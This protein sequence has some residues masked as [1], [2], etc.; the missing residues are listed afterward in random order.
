MSSLT[1]FGHR[2]TNPY[3]DHSADAHSH[4]IDWGAEFAEFDIQMTS[5]G[6]L[7]V[8][9]DTGTIPVTTYANL[10]ARDPDVL[11]LEEGLALVA[12][13][14]AETGRTINVS[15]EIKNPA[16]HA[17]VNLDP[18]QALVDLLS[19]QDDV[20]LDAISISSFDDAV[21]QR[22]SDDLMPDAGI[23]VALD[24][25]AT[26]FTNADMAS[27]AAWATSIS[28]NISYVNAE[29]VSAAHDAG[30]LYF[31]WTH[32]G[33]GEELQSLIDMGVDGVY[34]DNTRVARQYIDTVDGLNTVYGTTDGDNVSG[35]ARADRIYALQGDDT[36]LG[37]DGDDILN[38]D[39]GDDVLS[40]AAGADTIL[41][42][43]GGDVLFGGAG[44][45]MLDGG[46]GDDAIATEGTD[47][48]LFRA[49]SGV[50]LIAAN[51]DAT[52][53]LT[54]IAST[55][56]T[57]TILG[58]SLVVEAGEDAL[59]LQ[60]ATI[61]SLVFADDVTLTAAELSAM[62]TGPAAGTY[63]DLADA[64][65]ARIAGASD[66]AHMAPTPNLVVNGSFEDI[67]GTSTRSWGR[68]DPSGEMPGWVNLG[69]GRVEQHQD[70][71]DGVSANDGAYWSDL[72]GWQNNVELAQT[73]EGIEK[74]ATYTL[75]FDLADTDLADDESLTVTWGGRT[76]YEATPD[77]AEWETVTLSV[78]GGAGN[79]SDTL[80][81]AQGDGSRDG[82]GLALDNV[83]MVKAEDGSSRDGNLIANA[84]FE[85]INGTSYMSGGRYAD[86]EIAEWTDL[87]GGRIEL[88]GDA[89]NG[90]EARDADYWLDLG[91]AGNNV[92]LAQT[93]TGVTA[94]E[95]YT[96][97][98]KVAATDTAGTDAVR[99]TWGG[100]VVYE[101][102]P[103]ARWEKISV[104]V[105]G[106]A[107]DGSDRLVF[108]NVSESANA[109]GIALDD[110]TL[111]ETVP[112]DATQNAG[113]FNFV[114]IPYETDEVEA[115]MI[116]V[117]QNDT[118]NSLSSVTLELSG[119][120][121][122]FHIDGGQS[123]RGDYHVYIGDSW[124]GDVD[125]GIIIPTIAQNGV[126]HG[127]GQ[128]V[129]YGTVGIE[130]NVDADYFIALA[131]ADGGSEY[132]ASVSASYFRYDEFTAGW[133]TPTGIYRGSDD[134]V[135][136]DNVD[137]LDTGT[138]L[139]ELDGVDTQN[140]GIL[141]V[142][143]GK[144]EDNYAL[145]R[146][147][148]DGSG[149]IVQV[150]DNGAVGPDPESD[151]A[152]F[153]YLGVGETDLTFGRVLSSGAST[154]SNGDY[155]IEKVGVGQYYLTIDGYDASM[156]TLS[157]S[158]E[159]LDLL[160]AD[161]I[162]SFEAYEDGWL[163]E[164]RDTNTQ[165]LQDAGAQTLRSDY[166][167]DPVPTID[168]AYVGTADDYVAI[169]QNADIDY[170]FVI[171]HRGG[172]FQNAAEAL[173]ENSMT[174]LDYAVANGTN[175]IEI[176]IR[177][178]SDG[179]YVLMHDE[180]IDRTT[181]G[182]GS[183]ANMTLE[184]LKSFSIT[185]PVT[186][187]P[188]DETVPTLA[189]FLAASEGR[190]MLNLDMKLDL[191]DY[192]AVLQQVE[193]A[194]MMEYVVVKEE[195]YSTDDIA[196]VAETFATLGFD[197]GFMPQVRLADINDI[198]FLT[199]VLTTFGPEGI[200]VHMNAMDEDVIQS[201][202]DLI[203]DEAKALL[204][205]YDVRLWI[206]TIYGGYEHKGDQNGARDDFY[207][208]SDAD[209]VWGYWL[210][211]GISEIQT[212][213]T[214]AAIDYY[215]GIGARFRLDMNDVFGRDTAD[216][217]TGSS[218][219]DRIDALGGNDLVRAGNGDDLLIGGIGNDTFDGGAGSD[220]V[221]YG[222]EGAVGVDLRRGAASGEEIGRDRLS[223]IENVITGAGDDT[224]GGDRGAN[225]IATGGGDDAIDGN[226]GNDS[227]DGGAGDDV[228]SGGLGADFLSGGAGDD[229]IT[230]GHGNDRVVGGDGDD[231]IM[232]KSLIWRGDADQVIVDADDGADDVYGFNV[233]NDEVVLSDGGTYSLES[234]RG[235]TVLTYGETVI[236]FH[237][238]SLTDGDIILL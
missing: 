140:D 16:A 82:A 76:I 159:G 104:E 160:N 172:I 85:N 14:S 184:A 137:L 108:T 5:D 234:D 47:T 144:N 210:D 64:L 35:T 138:Y 79:G 221:D 70:T 11:T 169:W 54:D 154:V 187:A 94:G 166:F 188:L 212:D 230:A 133:L 143:G 161:N 168:P 38:G 115:G 164:T 132:N 167:G 60:D 124:D 153:V 175:M 100:A 148:D 116:E 203:S 36:V 129:Q 114:F 21:L 146:P 198:E 24:Y 25:L 118:S 19:A 46:V 185:D 55:A 158:A 173:P 106:G 201:D 7:V 63:T 13:K 131:E 30:L 3:P 23:D 174:S 43:A 20:A 122:G 33:T 57:V 226:L 72:D 91:G 61:G 182:S 125:E 112:V 117:T 214:A 84:S 86:G 113:A 128:G 102:T 83:T 176:D 231:T 29:T 165:A 220:T 93:V 235:D 99:V 171:G 59:I 236:T 28:G 130:D 78:V 80:V 51:T 6:V 50:D 31:T 193:D 22:L 155:E 222:G 142:A 205:E 218:A 89:V 69:S 4:A 105:T 202:G 123:N 238:T 77:S 195:L 12:E 81:I 199:E 121:D 178:T 1:I 110:V 136:G 134:L 53:R 119:G 180:T 10:L 18:A 68:Y 71:V 127:Q 49:G 208:L 45:D 34:T 56:V 183:V 74:G 135:W 65:V 41:G 197:V 145:S 141:L 194:G 52:V 27:I 209:A 90:I 217:L 200:E 229:T 147:L 162:V 156:G 225:R 75:T 39:G 98:F 101:G 213:E 107:G 189:E 37:G 232:L 152:A 40:G 196:T 224:V 157:V 26:N 126:D 58:G 120:T 32:N 109:T 233:R 177:K 62:A 190:M 237:D 204:D 228:V 88:H 2:G 179:A 8:A 92:A 227:V 66:A 95:S 15:I 207:A 216:R 9:H 191:D 87:E 192:V 48:I 151:P 211:E 17:A 150:H 111:E 42:G 206:N 44:A 181:N 219:D 97:T 103:D 163:I 186:G 170:A 223:R 215:N 67:D 73:I 96:L 139:V 149:Y